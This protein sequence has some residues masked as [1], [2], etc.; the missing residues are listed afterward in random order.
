MARTWSSLASSSLHL[1]GLRL[2]LDGAHEFDSNFTALAVAINAAG[3]ASA[4]VG[5]EDASN[6]G[7]TDF[8]EY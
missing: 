2:D 6:G 1:N 7:P 4:L 3:T 5:L 8:W